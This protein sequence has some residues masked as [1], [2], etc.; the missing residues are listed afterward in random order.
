MPSA[1]AAL[2]SAP[3]L[4]RAATFA[5]SF[6]SA[7]CASEAADCACTERQASNSTTR[8]AANIRIF[9]EAISVPPPPFSPLPC[10]LKQLIHL[11]LAVAKRVEP[12]AH[13]VEERQ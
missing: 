13:L 12:H 9:G 8:P 10:V 4:S 2:T 11:P 1:W 6:F 5:R 7:A 3:C